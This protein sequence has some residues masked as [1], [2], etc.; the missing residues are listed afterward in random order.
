MQIGSF[1]ITLYRY[2]LPIPSTIRWCAYVDGMEE[3]I[4]PGYGKYV[5]EALTDLGENIEIWLD[6]QEKSDAQ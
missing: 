5:D 2:S 6:R 3:D 1:S 4:P